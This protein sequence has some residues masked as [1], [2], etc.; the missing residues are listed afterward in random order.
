MK[1]PD[2]MKGIPLS[3]RVMPDRMIWIGTPNGHYSV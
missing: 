1:M 3:S 2:R